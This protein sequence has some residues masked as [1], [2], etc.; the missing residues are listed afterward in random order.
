MELGLS[1]KVAIVTGA[2]KGL[3]RA[4]AR[5]FAGEGANVAICSRDAGEI[6]AAAEELR[7]SGEPST[8]RPPT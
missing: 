5:E 4:I 3:G 8:R 6:E 7:A 1:G 2:S